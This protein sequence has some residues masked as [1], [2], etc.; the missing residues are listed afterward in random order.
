MSKKLL[1]ALP[2]GAG[3]LTN[4]QHGNAPQ[5]LVET[6]IRGAPRHG[7]HQRDM[8]D[9]H[10]DTRRLSAADSCGCAQVETIVATMGLLVSYNVD[11]MCP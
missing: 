8:H 7:A 2:L 1:S 5:S 6:A 4:A 11:R 10:I 3:G 9:Y